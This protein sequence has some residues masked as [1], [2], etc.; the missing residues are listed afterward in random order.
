MASFLIMETRKPKRQICV[1]FG[2]G[3]TLETFKAGPFPMTEDVLRHFYFQLWSMKKA[4][5]DLASWSTADSLLSHWAPSYLPLMTRK[6]AKAKIKSLYDRFRALLAGSRK[7]WKSNAEKKG[8]FLEELKTRFDISARG[9]MDII[10]S[11]KTLTKEEK[12][13]DTRFLHAIRDNRP[14]SLGPLDVKRIKRLERAAKRARLAE[15]RA[16]REHQRRLVRL[17]K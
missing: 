4:D 12:E 6:N 16:D 9:A 3:E 15:E 5:A 7:K 8:Q 14:H 13:E 11:D 17:Y 1:D 2:I 10:A